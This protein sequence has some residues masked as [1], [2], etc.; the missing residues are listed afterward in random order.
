[1]TGDHWAAVDAY[2]D[3]L[4]VPDDPVLHGALAASTRGGLPDHHVAPN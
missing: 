1:M 3:G 2:L 4:F